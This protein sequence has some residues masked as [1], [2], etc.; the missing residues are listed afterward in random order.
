VG[1]RRALR[2][3]ACAV[4]PFMPAKETVLTP[5]AATIPF[6][7]P[8]LA[9]PFQFVLSGSENLQILAATSVAGVTLQIHARFL[10]PDGTISPQSW[11]VAPPGDRSVQTTQFPV[12]AGTLLTLVI[13]PSA[14]TPRYGECYARASII[15]GFGGATLLLGTLT[16]GYTTANQ[17]LAWPGSPLERSID[18]PG[19]TQ[20]GTFASAALPFIALTVPAG[21]RWL[22]RAISFVYSATVANVTANLRYTI[23]GNTLVPMSFPSVLSIAPWNLLAAPDIATLNSTSNP[24]V[25]SLQIPAIQLPTAS[26]LTIA[27]GGAGAGD[28]VTQG[29]FVVQEWLEV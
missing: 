10:L 16:A 28:A 3:A 12:G 23:N 19:V 4:L 22:F 20:T 7:S 2:V 25:Q 15:Q 1:L 27:P 21:A 17:P 5:R 29:I 18:G 24:G 11:S 14:G 26:T 8:L 9:T 6:G 13:F